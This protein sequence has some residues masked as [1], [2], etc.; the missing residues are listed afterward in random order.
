[1]ESSRFERLYHQ[2][3]GQNFVLRRHRQRHAL[4]IFFREFQS[5][6]DHKRNLRDYN[7][8]IECDQDILYQ[9]LFVGRQQYLLH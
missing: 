5:F 1:M 2:L 8:H 3:L 9:R 6:F 7:N 4:E